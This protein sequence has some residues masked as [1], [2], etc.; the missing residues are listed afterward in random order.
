MWVCIMMRG[1]VQGRH[2]NVWDSMY[3]SRLMAFTHQ[4]LSDITLF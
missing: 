2:G 3:M 4:C 1:G